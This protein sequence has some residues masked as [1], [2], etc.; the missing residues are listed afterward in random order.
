MSNRPNLTPVGGIDE[1]RKLLAERE[2]MYR[3]AMTAELDVTNQSASDAV[4]YISRLV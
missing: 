4:V 1:V 3:S 2:P